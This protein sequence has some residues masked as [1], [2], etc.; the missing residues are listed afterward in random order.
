M[1]V[2]F[3]L[4]FAG[5]LSTAEAEPISVETLLSKR[6][7]WSKYKGTELQIEGRWSILNESR[8]LL[9]NCD[10]LIFLLDD[11]VNIPTKK[12]RNV[13][14]T[15]TFDTRGTK[16]VFRVTR[17]RMRLEDLEQVRV[18][19][20][21]IKLNDAESWYRLADWTSNRAEFYEDDELA[22]EAIA[23]YRQGVQAEHRRL[24]ANDVDGLYELAD[25]IIELELPV[26]LR[27]EFLHE[28]V[29]RELNAARKRKADE[30]PGV[31]THAL[32]HLPGS[33]RPLTLDEETVRLREAY[34][35]DPLTVYESAKPPVRRVLNRMLYAEAALES[36]ESGAAEDGRNGFEIAKRI[37]ETIPEFTELAESYRRREIDYQLE[38]A[39]DLPRAELL[40]L[41]TRLEERDQQA[42][43]EEVKLRWLNAREETFRDRGL[44]GLLELAEESIALLGDEDRA[45]DI[46][47][48]IYRDPAGV[49][50]GR[51]RLVQL[52][53][54]YIDEEWVKADADNDDPVAD[55]IRR[56]IVRRDMTDD[57]VRAALGGRPESVLRMAAR[58]G[59]T[60]FW[61]YPDHGV[62]IRFARRSVEAARTVVD[63]TDL[64]TI[65]DY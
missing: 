15:G 12:S 46:Y 44:R 65:R 32:E 3:C 36:I 61:I 37:E 53:Y 21:E 19:R 58:N 43:A 31:L 6:D 35:N 4:L 22:A 28:A 45:A 1:A 14:V 5:G 33:D 11:S 38:Q 9:T 2:A 41:V 39:A 27:E 30:Y 57:Q 23:L 40:T 42:R 20:G 24:P 49:E 17:L 7:D 51:E 48:E 64:S 60:E 10:D 18:W 25:R 63:I 54:E 62:A 59:I 8:L 55:A 47:R 26:E 52:G 16:L 50:L 34:Q 56:G 29:R 13:E